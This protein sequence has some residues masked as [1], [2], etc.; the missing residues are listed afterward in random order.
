MSLQDL[1]ADSHPSPSREQGNLDVA[2]ALCCTPLKKTLWEWRGV[3]AQKGRRQGQPLPA[4]DTGGT[5]ARR[6]GDFPRV[7]GGFDLASP[8]PSSQC[9]SQ[10]HLSRGLQG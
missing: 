2:T 10:L 5:L 8:S 9:P 6:L 1:P 4:L 3:V 7:G